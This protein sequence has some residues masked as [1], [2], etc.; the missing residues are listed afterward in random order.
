MVYE[1]EQQEQIVN[2]SPDDNKRL[3]QFVSL[4]RTRT[5]DTDM[6][7]GLIRHARNAD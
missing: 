1:L 5:E 6:L 7:T 4:E 3:M 2:D